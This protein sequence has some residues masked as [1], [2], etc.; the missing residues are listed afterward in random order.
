MVRA[1]CGE[2]AIQDWHLTSEDPLSIN[3]APGKATVVASP[4][5]VCVPERP[6]DGLLPDRRTVIMQVFAF[7]RQHERPS[8][9]HY[10]RKRPQTF[11]L[12]ASPTVRYGHR[13]TCI[14]RL[15]PTLNA[16][17]VARVRIINEA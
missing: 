10:V 1:P 14:T 3:L 2:A 11:A 17:G 4:A 13:K 12:V 6:V 8:L 9:C 5:S 16:F 7:Q 15:F